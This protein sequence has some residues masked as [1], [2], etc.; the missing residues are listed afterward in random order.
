MN[1]PQ[2]IGRTPCEECRGTGKSRDESACPVCAG[3]GLVAAFKQPTA[4]D[5][6]PSGFPRRRRFPRFHT[7]LPIRLR[8]QREQEFTGR[9]AVI[10]EGGL[11]A[12]LP[13]P[14]PSGSVVTL[15]LSFPTYPT[16]LETWAIVRNQ[17]GLR[18]GFEFVSLTDPERVAIRQFCNGLTVQSDD[19]YVGSRARSSPSEQNGI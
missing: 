13:E 11:A 2:I 16:I 1:E 6:A 4:V 3:T 15:Q 17:I 19:G 9:C 7:D 8:D 18:H 14:I 10:A 12:V 5:T